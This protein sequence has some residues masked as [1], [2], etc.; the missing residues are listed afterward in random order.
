MYIYYIGSWRENREEENVKH[1]ISLYRAC[2]SAIN[3]QVGTKKLYSK[4]KLKK[5]KRKKNKEDNSNK[6]IMI[7]QW[8]L[9]P[10]AE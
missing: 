9:I 6:L 4:L 7:R 10:P 1:I 3:L 5:I 8:E 2:I